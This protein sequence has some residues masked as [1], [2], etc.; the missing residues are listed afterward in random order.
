L[1]YS[2]CYSQFAVGN[3]AVFFEIFETEKKIELYRILRASWNLP[4]YFEF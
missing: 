3:Y 2:V 4:D 1:K